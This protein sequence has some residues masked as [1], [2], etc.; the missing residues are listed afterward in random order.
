MKTLVLGHI[1]NTFLLFSFSSGEVGI[2]QKRQLFEYSL[3]FTFEEF[4]TEYINYLVDG[5]APYRRLIVQW[6][7]YDD[8]PFFYFLF[9]MQLFESINKYQ[10]EWGLFYLP[11]FF[12][13]SLFLF[14]NQ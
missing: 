3:G 9:Q 11:F 4:N 10:F 12:S 2:P 5:V 6:R 7:L 8:H 14:S 13:L 1:S